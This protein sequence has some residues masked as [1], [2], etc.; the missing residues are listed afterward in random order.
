MEEGG[1]GGPAPARETLRT[2]DLDNRG[3]LQLQEAAMAQQD[4]ELEQLERSVTSTKVRGFLWG[5]SPS[6]RESFLD[7]HTCTSN[8]SWLPLP[9]GILHAWRGCMHP[10]TDF[11]VPNRRLPKDLIWRP[12][13]ACARVHALPGHGA[14]WSACVQRTLCDT[15]MLTCLHA[16]R[17]STL[18]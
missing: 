5:S 11:A 8:Q 18:R 7:G 15:A 14:Q 6:I 10:R 13:D 17:C 1:R 2:A 16:C 4:A 12:R 3:I 9:T